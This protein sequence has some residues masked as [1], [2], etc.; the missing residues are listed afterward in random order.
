MFLALMYR[1]AVNQSINLF[2]VE[3]IFFR[4]VHMILYVINISMYFHCKNFLKRH[5]HNIFSVSLKNKKMSIIR[6][7]IPNIYILIY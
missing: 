2:T 6:Y 1:K 4:A 3:H 5:I 7:R